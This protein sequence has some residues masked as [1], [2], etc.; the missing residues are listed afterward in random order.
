MSFIE[1]FEITLAVLESGIIEEAAHEAM[2]TPQAFMAAESIDNIKRSITNQ[3]SV[4]KSQVKNKILNAPINQDWQQE[5]EYYQTVKDYSDDYF[6]DNINDIIAQLDINSPFYESAH[7]LVKKQNQQYN[8]L[9]KH[10]FCDKWYQTLFESLQDKKRED[11]QQ[12]KQKLLDDLYQRQETIAQLSAVDDSGNAERNMRLW[13]LAKAKLSQIDISSLSKTVDFLTKNSELQTIAEQLGRIANQSDDNDINRIKVE[14]IQTT[15]VED[16]NNSGEL[17]G[18]HQSNDLENL[19]PTELMFLAYP[20]LEVIF[21]KHLAEKRLGTYQQKSLVRK[22]ENIVTYEQK[23]KQADE[24]KGPFIIAIDA[25][26][27]MMGLAEK[28]AKAFAYGLMQIALAEDRECY[29]I[30]FSA[31]QVT[32]ELTKDNGLREML[33]FLS[34]SFHGGT[35]IT[36]VMEKSLSLMKTER[37][38]NADLI[39]LSD[40]M[41][42]NLQSK[43]VTEINAMKDQ[44]NRFHALSLSHYRNSQLIDLF[45]YHWEYTPSKLANMKRLFTFGS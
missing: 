21:Y 9:F 28:S 42:P 7:A 25:S 3:V 1:G 2:G 26:G 23:S 37:Y 44:E 30:I 5:V 41:A 43:T 32:Y 33:S 38:K 4:W 24:N 34:Y 16:F 27:S 11:I 20:E 45:D 36:T 12:E 15:S 35:D 19:L 18:I 22:N 10:F 40:F 6:L 31:Q 14:K 29:V 8:P 39:V 13:D 17:S